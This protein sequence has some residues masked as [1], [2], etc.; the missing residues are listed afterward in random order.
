M[1]RYLIVFIVTI[2]AASAPAWSD[3]DSHETG[4]YQVIP[5]AM[6]PGP[7]G[8]LQQRTI[9]LD[10]ATGR[11]WALASGTGPDKG[12]G[13]NWMPLPVTDFDTQQ[14]SASPAREAVKAEPEGSDAQEQSEGG[15]YRDRLWNYERDP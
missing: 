14:A 10:T 5:D 15:G 3:D 8:K 1:I 12:Q 6:V 7:G 11:T 4:R 9:L 2:L 13:A